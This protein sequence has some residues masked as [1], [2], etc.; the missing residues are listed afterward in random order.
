MRSGATRPALQ[1]RVRVR[2]R[3]VP[4]AWPEDPGRPA[5]LAAPGTWWPQASTC[6]STRR[7]LK[8]RGV[9]GSAPRALR[10]PGAPRG[11]PR[12][13]PEPRPRECGSPPCLTRGAGA[14]ARGNTA[15]EAARSPRTPSDGRR[16]QAACTGRRGVAA[17]AFRGDGNSE[18]PGVGRPS[19]SKTR[20]NGCHLARRTDRRVAAGEAAGGPQRA[21]AALPRG[22][23]D[24]PRDGRVPQGALRA[25]GRAA[26]CSG[27]TPRR[28]LSV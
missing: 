26:G 1:R 24:A 23:E 3:R 21:Q 28:G 14:G 13:S 12:E 16:R 25:V 11:R 4:A 27:D 19:P 2:L 17:S 9:A 10:E 18:D 6:A 7:P 15:R 5:L 22:G 20:A 8:P